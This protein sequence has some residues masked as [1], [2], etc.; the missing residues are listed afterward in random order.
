VGVLG[1][2]TGKATEP[3]R[4]TAPAQSRVL[5]SFSEEGGLAYQYTSLVVSTHRDA[6]VTRKGRTVRFQ[7][8]RARWSKLNA[9]LKH[10]DLSAVAGDYPASPGAADYMTYVISVG[11][12]SVRATDISEL[13][14]RVSH[15]VEP[16]R[17]VLEEIVAVGRRRLP[18]TPLV[19]PLPA[20]LWR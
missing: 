19:G 17:Q 1:A 18:R 15:E 4:I 16:L 14:E 6:T 11:R 20:R 9:I 10:T 12:H 3:K 5:V 7:L 13:P 8:D 2:E